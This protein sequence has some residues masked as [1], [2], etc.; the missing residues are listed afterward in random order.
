MGKLEPS[1]HAA[2]PYEFRCM[3]SVEGKAPDLSSGEQGCAC[4]S[5][6][7]LFRGNGTA[8]GRQG[9]H[10][11]QIA[12]IEQARCRGMQNGLEAGRKEAC[13]MAR[14]GLSPSLK[15]LFHTL[16]DLSLSS[17][18]MKEQVSTKV[19]ELALSISERVMGES[20]RWTADSMRD[21]KAHLADA[22]SQLNR[23]TLHLNPSDAQA[24]EALLADE[25]IQWPALEQINIERD[26]LVPPGEARVAERTIPRAS[27]DGGVLSAL[28]AL[29]SKKEPAAD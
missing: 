9:N 17:Q 22:L 4:G 1:H 25:G 3:A 13:R 5:F 16:N 27:I 2:S 24:I 23:V 26:A 10:Q 11:E 21:L 15:G 8:D 18:Q 28:A 19:I 12:Q 14:G 20:A 6:Q 7:P 29:L